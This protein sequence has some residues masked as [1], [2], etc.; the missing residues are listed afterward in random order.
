[1]VKGKFT[2]P[3]TLANG[4][5]YGCG[6]EAELEPIEAFHLAGAGYFSPESASAGQPKSDSQDRANVATEEHVD[7]PKLTAPL[8]R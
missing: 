2:Q 5:R 7:P 6:D 1:M 4:T 3:A 8:K